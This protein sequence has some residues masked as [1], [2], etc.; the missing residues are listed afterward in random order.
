MK[1]HLINWF[2]LLETF[3]RAPVGIFSFSLPGDGPSLI[4]MS[5]SIVEKILINLTK[6]RLKSLHWV[7]LSS[8]SLQAPPEP[9]RLSLRQPERASLRSLLQM[10][11]TRMLMIIILSGTASW[12]A[13]TF[14]R[15]KEMFQNKICSAQTFHFF[16]L[17]TYFWKLTKDIKYNQN[18]KYSKYNTD[19]DHRQR[20]R[21]R[22]GRRIFQDED[23]VMSRQLGIEIGDYSSRNRRNEHKYFF[24]TGN[25]NSIRKVSVQ[26]KEGEHF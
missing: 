6:Y 13:G 15:N 11:M 26:W 25:I 2:D 20:L 19:R 22:P 10:E 14:R 8:S 7:C 1:I 24:Q 9:D 21:E 23:Q 12:S 5:G 16:S 17:W 18:Q 3:H 4:S